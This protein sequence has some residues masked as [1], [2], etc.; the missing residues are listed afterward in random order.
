MLT[1]S[2]VFSNRPHLVLSADLSEQELR[3]VDSETLIRPYATEFSMIKAAK[4][5]G[6]LK[7][8]FKDHSD[9]CFSISKRKLTAP[10]AKANAPLSARNARAGPFLSAVCEC[11]CAA[12]FVALV[13]V[14]VRFAFRSPCSSPNAAGKMS[15]SST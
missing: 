4:R 5:A 14:G 3:N 7:S 13:F 9:V 11:V 1:G 15:C 10:I 6:L 2:Q 12:C 8:A